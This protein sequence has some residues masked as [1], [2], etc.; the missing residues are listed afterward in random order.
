MTG[1]GTKNSTGSRE[2]MS[3][4]RVSRTSRVNGDAK[5]TGDRFECGMR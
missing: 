4:T 5:W 1:R 3:E 2:S